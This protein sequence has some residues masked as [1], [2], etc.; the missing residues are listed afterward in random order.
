MGC[1]DASDDASDS[2]SDGNRFSIDNS[3][4]RASCVYVSRVRPPS[5]E[6]FSST[7]VS[8]EII[9]INDTTSH[10][11]VGQTFYESLF[12][13][14]VS[15][16]D[17]SV[18]GSDGSSEGES[19]LLAHA[20]ENVARNEQ[21][22]VINDKN[23]LFMH[24][25]INGLSSKIFDSD[26]MSFVS[27]FHFICLVETFVVTFNLPHMFRGFNVF[28]QP[29]KKLS[30]AG[31]PSG[32]VICLIKNEFV[33]FIKQINVTVGNFLLFIID[34]SLFGVSKNVLYVCA[35]IPPEGSRYYSYIESE[36]DGIALL[37]NCLID[38]AIADNDVFI[39][40]SGDLNSRTANVSHPLSVEDDF[41]NAVHSSKPASTGRQS[42][43]NV[44]NCFGKSLLNM[45]TT[46]NLC[47]L[48]GMCLGDLEGRYTYISDFGCS[49][50]DYFLLSSDLLSTVWDNCTLRIV[51]RTE[52]NHL[53]VVLSLVFP[54]ENFIECLDVDKD[55]VIEKFVWDLKNAQ[56]FMDA[57]NSET[58]KLPL[59]N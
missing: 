2:K 56:Q 9:D 16:S 57:I 25:N 6:S 42:Q 58:Q 13:A 28:C 3:E 54:K 21:E 52:T 34:K 1:N 14:P 7:H 26:F 10:V 24:W 22:N 44:F 29:A 20:V 33:P 41:F 8:D 47:I 4:S 18:S 36:T 19:M 38:N 43:D 48:N 27:S 32:G 53:P 15:L 17:V 5:S 55:I 51:D 11:H 39:I 31:R 45:C 46:L 35:Y 37:E 23:F 59:R 50:I 30:D 12:G 49:V 40:L